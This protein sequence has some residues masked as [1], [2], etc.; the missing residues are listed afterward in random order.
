MPASDVYLHN[1]FIAYKSISDLR[2][3]FETVLLLCLERLLI[4]KTVATAESA[5]AA[6]IAPARIPPIAVLLKPD[7]AS[8]GYSVKITHNRHVTSNR[9]E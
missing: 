3:R 5:K 7:E 4:I 8:F 9:W 2:D 1:Q 6:A